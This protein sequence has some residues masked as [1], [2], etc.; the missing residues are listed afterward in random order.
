ML[1]D[2]FQYA[3]ELQE[4][5]EQQGTCAVLHFTARHSCVLTAICSS[6]A[7]VC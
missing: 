7:L 3:A 5:L 6:H 4:S 1:D 2:F